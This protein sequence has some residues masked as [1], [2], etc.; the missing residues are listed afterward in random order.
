MATHY[1]NPLTAFLT[2]ANVGDS[3]NGVTVV[4]IER[5]GPFWAVTLDGH[6]ERWT[7]D[8]PSNL[9]SE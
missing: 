8:Y 1:L 5:H 2:T 6:G 9:R 3:F 4:S 7:T